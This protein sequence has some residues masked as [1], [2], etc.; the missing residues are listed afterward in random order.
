M[1]LKKVAYKSEPKMAHGYLIVIYSGKNKAVYRYAHNLKHARTVAKN[2][3]NGTIVEIY[4]Q[5]NN[6]VQAYEVR[7]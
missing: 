3:R 7:K 5:D 1:K 6:F 4:R 2:R